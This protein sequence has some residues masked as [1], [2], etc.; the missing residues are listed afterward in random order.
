MVINQQ[1]WFALLII[2]MKKVNLIK[3]QRETV[4]G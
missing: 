2:E 4:K 3:K 1:Q